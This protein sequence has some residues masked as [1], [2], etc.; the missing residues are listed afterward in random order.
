MLKPPPGLSVGPLGIPREYHGVCHS[1]RTVLWTLVLLD[2]L[3]QQGHEDALTFTSGQLDALIKAALLHDAGREGE[4][5]DLPEWEL[6]SGNLCQQHLL[7]IGHDML[8]ANDAR[9][10]IIEKNTRRRADKTLFDRLLH[11]A[12]CLEVMRVRGE[13]E[14]SYLDLYAVL[15][16]DT[17]YHLARQVRDV[18]SRQSDLHM[19][20]LII[21]HGQQI[22]GERKQNCSSMG[23]EARATKG[24]FEWAGRPF[25]KQLSWLKATSPSLHEHI[26]NVIG[27]IPE[28]LLIREDCYERLYFILRH[29]PISLKPPFFYT[30]ERSG[31]SYRVRDCSDHM[32]AARNE[33]LMTK[34]AGLSGLG[35]PDLRLISHAERALLF[36]DITG[37]T[38][39]GLSLSTA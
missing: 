6:E 8:Q 7:A 33:V 14:L 30:D 27:E 19:D 12:D 3:K 24:I 23:A 28:A 32:A 1:N 11:D 35:V 20:C 21:D 4:G 29:E 13:F 36:S 2:L 10:A 17:C 37:F 18:I 38:S 9:G 34:L 39:A 22:P 31:R 15:G 16:R 25:L 26:A 5:G